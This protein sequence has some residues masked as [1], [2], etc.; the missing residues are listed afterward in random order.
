MS[1]TTTAAPTTTGESCTGECVPGTSEEG[2]VCGCGFELRKCQDDCTWSDWVCEG[3]DACGLWALPAGAGAW[4][5]VRW[6]AIANP[7]H[8]PSSAVEAAFGADA[9]AIGVVLTHDTFHIL[10]VPGRTWTNSGPRSALFPEAEGVTF[11]AA[12]SVNLGLVGNGVP[13]AKE[14]ITLLS[15]DRVWIYDDFEPQGL[16][17]KYNGDMP[18]CDGNE[19][20][21]TADAPDP[22]LVRAFWIDVVGDEL[23]VNPDISGCDGLAN[24]TQMEAY[25][26]G[27]SS[28]R[29]GSAHVSDV[30]KCYDF[31]YSAPVATYPPMTLP[32]APTNVGRI[33]G[34]FFLHGIYVVGSNE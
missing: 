13:S 18:C 14:G 29:G 6:D 2:E 23:W 8:A 11:V 24:G 19:D 33:G 12:Y 26:A 34:A 10:D 30:G 22:A 32:A 15:A 16:A 1:S 4:V 9:T 27:L 25:A 5:E 7:D 3:E 20:W 31:I 28:A 17:P 21:Q